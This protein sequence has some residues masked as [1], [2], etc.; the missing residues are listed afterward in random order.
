MIYPLN[1]QLEDLLESFVDPD[2]GEIREGLTEEAMQ[3][4]VEQLQ[5][6]HDDKLD[7]L[8]A[9]AKNYKAEASDIREEKMKLAKRQKSA[10]NAF[11]RAKNYIGLLLGGDKFKN[12]KHSVYYLTTQELVVDDKEGLLEWAKVNAPGFLNEPTIREGDLKQA[13]KNGLNIPFAHLQEN[14]NVVVR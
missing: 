8:C 12:P 9:M 2:T 13:M 1:Q 7:A 11:E 4:A 3:E 5:M 6:E 10:E 14:K